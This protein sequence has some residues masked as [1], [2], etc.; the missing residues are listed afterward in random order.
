MGAVVKNLG[1][2]RGSTV[3]VGYVLQGSGAGGTSLRIG[4]VGDDTPHETGPGGGFSIGWP[5]VL[6]GGRP[7]V[8]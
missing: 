7:G 6:Q 1:I 8:F 4:D 3:S 2:G 5:G